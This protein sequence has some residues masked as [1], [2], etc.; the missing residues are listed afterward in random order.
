MASYGGDGMD[1]FID[2][3]N[4]QVMF[5]SL[6]YGAFRKTVNGGLTWS[7]IVNGLSGG[8]AWV[9]PFK[10]DPVSAQ[11]L[12]AGYSQLFVSTD[13]GLSWTQLANTGG[14]GYVVEFAIAPSDNQTIY[15]IHGTSLRKTVDGGSTWTN[16]T[17]NV[18]TGSGAPTFITVDPTDANTA[19]VTLSGYSAGN[20]VFQTT[21]G[22]TTWT[23]FPTTYQIYQQTV[24]FTR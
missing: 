13:Q 24:P 10:Q 23:M 7:G 6:Y 18:P 8:A 3:T 16:I 5:G 17:S 2:R 1:C 21:N 9:C 15:V 4:D 11:T 14:A 19:W 22:G 12:Y 20:K